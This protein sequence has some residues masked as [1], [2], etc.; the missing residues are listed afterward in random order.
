MKKNQSKE[1]WKL[2][3]HVYKLTIHRIKSY[4]HYKKVIKELTEKEKVTS[5]SERELREKGFSKMYVEAI[6]TAIE[7]YI[8]PEFR[9]AVKEHVICGANYDYLEQKYFLTKS[10][11]KRWTQRF[12]WAVDQELEIF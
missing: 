4:E 10:S 11:M 6:D 9:E 1:K 8:I 12:I 5:L 7:K 3:P 2:D